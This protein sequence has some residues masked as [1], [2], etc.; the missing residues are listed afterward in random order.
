MKNMKAQAA[1]EFLMTYGWALLVIVVVI[2]ALLW[3]NPFKTNESCLPESGASQGFSCGVQPQ[4]N[5]SAEIIFTLKNDAGK[6]IEVTKVYA[7]KGGAQIDATSIP[8]LASSV[9]IPS[10]SSKTF[11]GIKIYDENGN[12]ISQLSSGSA[13]RGKIIVKYKYSEDPSAYQARK[14]VFAVS[15]VVS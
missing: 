12:A 9:N 11:T 6:E 2:S 7:V 5:T 13:F 4:I 3:M 8:S 1:M 14:A 15:G 10:G